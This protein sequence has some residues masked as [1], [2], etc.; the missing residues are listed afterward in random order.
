MKTRKKNKVSKLNDILLNIRR[1]PRPM[2]TTYKALKLSQSRKKED[3]LKYRNNLIKHVLRSYTICGMQL[4]SKTTTINELAIILNTKPVKIIKYLSQLTNELSLILNK[5]SID[6][7]VRVLLAQGIEM[8]LSDRHRALNQHSL[9]AQSQGDSYK[10]FI[11]G[12]VNKSI[13]NLLESQKPL[14]DIIR[15]IQGQIGP[16]THINILNQN[17]ANHQTNL[18]TTGEALK[19]IEGSKQPI[20]L[21]ESEMQTLY[22]DNIEGTPEVH[23]STMDTG[24]KAKKPKE[25]TQAKKMS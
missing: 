22:L 14:I 15:T 6:Q 3:K 4:N 18:L 8:A 25:D 1:Y 7:T 13:K 23:A 21:N 17:N 19:M 5:D 10:P 16:N 2:G 12:E 9:L 11:S 24:L 20:A